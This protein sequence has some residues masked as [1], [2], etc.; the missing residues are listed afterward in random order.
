MYRLSQIER[1]NNSTLPHV[2]WFVW[3]HPTQQIDYHS[4]RCN[5][6]YLLPNTKLLWVPNAPNLNIIQTS[7]CHIKSRHTCCCATTAGSMHCVFIVHTGSTPPSMTIMII[8]TITMTIIIKSWFDVY[9][10]YC[11]HRKQSS[12]QMDKEKRRRGRSL[13][14]KVSIANHNQE[15]KCWP[16]QDI[17]A[18]S[19][20]WFCHGLFVAN[21]HK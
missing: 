11:T 12:L 7:V 5:D 21:H 13:K 20:L 16:T 17:T 10:L 2:V 8:L 1:T 19:M 15:C 6:R 9:C 3:H 4:S 18:W 14:I